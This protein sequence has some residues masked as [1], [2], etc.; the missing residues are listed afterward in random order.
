MTR[1][2]AVEVAIDVLRESCGGRCNVEHNP[3]CDAEAANILS[4]V[5]TCHWWEGDDGGPWATQCN[6]LFNI[7]NEGPDA[8]GMKFCCF[9]GKR[10]IEIAAHDDK[11]DEDGTPNV[12]SASPHK[13][14]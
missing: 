13:T 11:D 7:E 12:S 5:E 4:D 2:E 9:C 8:N 1:Q 6:E 3:C 14:D 10:L